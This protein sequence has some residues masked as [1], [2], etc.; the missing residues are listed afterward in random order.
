MKVGKR[1][2]MA[3]TKQSVLLSKEPIYEE[4]SWF[5]PCSKQKVLQRLL[6][7]HP[8]SP[9]TDILW[10]KGCKQGR[11]CNSWAAWWLQGQQEAS[12]VQAL[13]SILLTSSKCKVEPLR[14]PFPPP[15]CFTVEWFSFI[16]IFCPAVFS[17]FEGITSPWTHYTCSSF[18]LKFLLCLCIVKECFKI[19]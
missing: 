13:R 5:D 11:L 3:H 16:S 12:G 15:E 4:R 8:R 9:L 2:R 10:G 18:L 1:R 19:A 6:V 17:L 14:A 7:L